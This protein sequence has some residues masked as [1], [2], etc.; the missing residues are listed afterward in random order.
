MPEM[1]FSHICIESW[2]QHLFIWC[3]DPFIICLY[4][5]KTLLLG[6]VGAGSAIYNWLLFQYLLQDTISIVFFF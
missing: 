4:G 3:E 6:G 1:Q 2:K 5:V